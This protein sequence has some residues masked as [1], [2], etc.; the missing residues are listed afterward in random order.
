[1]CVCSQNTSIEHSLGN[2][3]TVVLSTGLR[4][5]PVVL[6][7]LSSDID[8]MG[9]THVPRS[10]DSDWKLLC[11]EDSPCHSSQAGGVSPQRWVPGWPASP[12][13]FHDLREL[14]TMW[15][16]FRRDLWE[17]SGSQKLGS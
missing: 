16:G 17:G 12:G 11:R 15:K 9:N 1:M 7:S 3:D 2:A 13:D 14:G 6:P 10:L 4:P 5:E 8:H